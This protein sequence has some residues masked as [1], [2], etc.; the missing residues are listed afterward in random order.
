MIIN[1]IFY[2]VKKKNILSLYNLL[3]GIINTE[4][5]SASLQTDEV[6]KIKIAEGG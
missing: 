1:V 2:N 5:E 3:T 6:I 4:G